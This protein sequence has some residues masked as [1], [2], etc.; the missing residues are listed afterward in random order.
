MPRVL[1][2]SS[3]GS[4]YGREA[5]CTEEGRMLAPGG[6]LLRD[7]QPLTWRVAMVFSGCDAPRQPSP[8]ATPQAKGSQNFAR[9][10]ET[11]QKR[12]DTMKS[13]I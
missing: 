3:E 5:V 10:S 7:P 13:K 1:L 6:P 8:V 4:A 11:G 12:R 2:Y 9:A